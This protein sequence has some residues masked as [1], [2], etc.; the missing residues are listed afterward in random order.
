MY[1]SNKLAIFRDKLIGL[2]KKLFDHTE[3]VCIDHTFYIKKET[4]T[5]SEEVKSKKK[6]KKPK[7]KQVKIPKFNSQVN[8]KRS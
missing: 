8:I 1:I 6:K 3:Q 7:A 2:D 5:E 4:E